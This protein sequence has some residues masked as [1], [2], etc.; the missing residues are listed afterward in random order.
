MR[1]G[2]GESG[3]QDV[4]SNTG[5]DVL[6]RVRARIRVEMCCVKVVRYREEEF[7]VTA[8]RVV[9]RMRYWRERPQC[10]PPRAN[11]PTSVMLTRPLLEGGSC[12]SSSTSAQVELLMVEEASKKEAAP[13][14]PHKNGT[15]RISSAECRSIAASNI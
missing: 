13:V 3:G 15:R 4:G 10:V 7:A 1:R 8:R 6:E 14:R 9:S 12:G 5:Q 11:C 2:S